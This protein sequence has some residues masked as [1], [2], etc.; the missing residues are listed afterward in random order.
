MSDDQVEP[1]GRKRWSTLI[2]EAM[3]LRAKALRLEAE[4]AELAG[5]AAERATCLRLA[6]AQERNARTYRAQAAG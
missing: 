2:A 3:E 1:P 4:A 5:D 6:D